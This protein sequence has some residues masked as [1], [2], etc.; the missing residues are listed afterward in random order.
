MECCA[1]FLQQQ[2]QQPLSPSRDPRQAAEKFLGLSRVFCAGVRRLGV[3]H[4]V[5]LDRRAHS[6]AH[7]HLAIKVASRGEWTGAPLKME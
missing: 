3:Q 2:Q 7:P 6:M 4:A 5:I 1:E